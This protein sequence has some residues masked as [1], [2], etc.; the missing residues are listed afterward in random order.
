MKRCGEDVG[1]GGG[2]GEKKGERHAGDIG[3]FIVIV[4][5]W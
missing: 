2:G 3:K 5:R 4:T 1:G